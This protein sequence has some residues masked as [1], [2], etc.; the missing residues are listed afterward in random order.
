MLGKKERRKDFTCT[1]EKLLKLVV[2]PVPTRRK[3]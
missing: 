3:C 2:I 1:S